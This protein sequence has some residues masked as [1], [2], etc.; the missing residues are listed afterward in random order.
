MPRWAFIASKFSA[1]IIMY[2]SGFAL[3]G[4]AAFYYTLFLFGTLDL[5]GFVL[6]N[7]LLLL[8]LLTFV[9][10]SLLGS[11]LGASTVAAGGISLGLSVALMLLGTLPQYGAFLPG[12]LLGWAALVGQ[13]AAGVASSMPGFGSGNLS[14]NGGAAASALVVIVMA[15]VLSLGVFEQQEL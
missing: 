5:G 11:T 12:A 10:L 2:A 6:L 4:V 13:E 3:A 7:G 15:L 14:A 1:Q 9:A 8:W